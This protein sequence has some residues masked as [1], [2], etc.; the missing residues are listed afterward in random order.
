MPGRGPHRLPGPGWHDSATQSC[1]CPSLPRSH[2]EVPDPPG[3]SPRVQWSPDSR[4]NCSQLPRT[5][6][7]P[8]LHLPGLPFASHLASWMSPPTSPW[9]C[10]FCPSLGLRPLSRLFS[11]KPQVFRLVKDSLSSCPKHKAPFPSLTH[12]QPPWSLLQGNLRPSADPQ[13]HPPYRGLSHGALPW[14]GPGRS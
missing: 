7:P 11:L 13:A 12:T 5:H 8:P 1:V 6:P 9:G 4:P 14:K 2:G 10:H 3:P